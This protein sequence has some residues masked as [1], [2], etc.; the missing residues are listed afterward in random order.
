MAL[1]GNLQDMSIADLF[2]V[3]RTGAKAGVLLLVNGREHGLIYVR[4]GQLIDAVLVRGAERRVIAHGEAAVLHILQWQD[5][6]F[7]F[8]HTIAVDQRPVRITHSSEWLVLESVRRRSDRFQVQPGEQITADSR[9]E[10][11]AAPL[12]AAVELGLDSEQW[13]ILSQ[14]PVS[15]NVRDIS[16]RSGIPI[17]RVILVL[18]ILSAIGL[19]VDAPAPSLH[20]PRRPRA[21]PAH[22][23][24][25]Q[26]AAAAVGSPSYHHSAPP[27]SSHL[28][29]RAIIRRVRD[30]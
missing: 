26:P 25:R 14:I 2:Q 7:V 12:S 17:D 11:T 5:A 19:V 22:H 18:R 16:A 28:L 20:P 8:R 24:R 30:L 3:F 29:L 27:T 10:L 23:Q 15:Q 6:S 1:E 9:I 4:A 13:H 21:E